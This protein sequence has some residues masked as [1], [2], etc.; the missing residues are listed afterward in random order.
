MDSYDSESGRI[1]Q[2]FS[3]SKR[4]AYLCTAQISKFQPNFATFTSLPL[5]A[6]PQGVAAGHEHV[7]AQVELVPVQE[8]GLVDVPARKKPRLREQAFERFS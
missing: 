1:L 7:D 6:D 5:A 4:F 2:H 3:R 8:E